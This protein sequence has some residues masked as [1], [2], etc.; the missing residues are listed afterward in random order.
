M[1]RAVGPRPRRIPR[2]PLLTATPFRHRRAGA[3]HAGRTLLD[4]W[5]Q[6]GSPT[7]SASAGPSD[8]RSAAGP[9]S[10]KEPRRQRGPVMGER[11]TSFRSSDGSASW[12][13]LPEDRTAGSALPRPAP[14][15]SRGAAPDP[16]DSTDVLAAAACLLDVSVHKTGAAYTEPV[17]PIVA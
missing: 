5:Q 3:G 2:P 16:G 6:V 8:T 14:L 7:L 4:R 17:D 11:P 13:C 1:D 10:G 9:D 12:P 15:P